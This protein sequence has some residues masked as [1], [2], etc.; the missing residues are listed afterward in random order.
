MMDEPIVGMEMVGEW[1]RPDESETQGAT[2]TYLGDLSVTVCSAK[3][4]LDAYGTS[5]AWSRFHFATT[6][7][8]ARKLQ[9]RRVSSASS[10][11][12]IESRSTRTTG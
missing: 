5:V 3:L 11:T 4:W 2:A 1:G 10:W 12:S 6:D 9:E 8:G 7:R